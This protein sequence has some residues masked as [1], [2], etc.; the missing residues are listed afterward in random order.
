MAKDANAFLSDIHTSIEIIEKHL[1]N[2]EN[3][4][5]YQHNFLVT[6]AVER[7]LAI[8]GEALNKALKLN[9]NIKVSH[10]KQII[11]LRHILVHDYDLVDDNTIWATVKIYLPVLKTEVKNLLIEKH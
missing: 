5:Q 2:I 4:A 7:R 10:Q 11:A 8:I 3:R 6:D 9:S 1:T